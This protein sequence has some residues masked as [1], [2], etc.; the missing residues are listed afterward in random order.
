MY[1]FA[2]ETSSTKKDRYIIIENKRKTIFKIIQCIATLISNIIIIRYFDLGFFVTTIIASITFLFTYFNLRKVTCRQVNKD[3][4]KETFLQKLK[5]KKYS[6]AIKKYGLATII[7][8]FALSNIII[9]FSMHLLENNIEF[10]LLKSIKNYAVVFAVIGYFIVRKA[11]IKGVEI[12]TTICM[13][14]VII[15]IIILSIYNPY[16]LILLMGLYTIDNLVELTGRFKIFENDTYQENNIEKNAI[17]DI[18]IFTAQG[19]ASLVLLNISFN[20]SIAIVIISV[21]IAIAL[22]IKC[23]KEMNKYIEEK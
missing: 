17:I 7:T 3:V 18:G 11:N 2:F 15:L 14:I 13:E 21:I 16:F 10:E 1:H 20:I 19:L 5:I 8:R 23:Q 22:K 6:T 4:K 12:K 9:L